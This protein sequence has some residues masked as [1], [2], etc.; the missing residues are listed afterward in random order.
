MVLLIIWFI[1]GIIGYQ[2]DFNKGNSGCFGSL[3]GFLLGPLG[4]LLIYF[5]SSNS[6]VLRQRSG[7]TK[8]CP[9]CKEYIKFNAD[10][11]KHCHNRLFEVIEPIEHYSKEQQLSEY[12]HKKSKSDLRYVDIAILTIVSVI[13]VSL[14]LNEIFDFSMYGFD[15]YRKQI[16]SSS[17]I[18]NLDNN[19]ELTT[20]EKE[21]KLIKSIR[22]E[23]TILEN[24]IDYS[25]YRGS[26]SSI[27]KEIKLFNKWSKI[28][29]D[30]QTDSSKEVKKIL[31]KFKNKVISNQVKEFP[32][33][34]KEFSKVIGSIGL[35]D[36]IEVISFGPKNTNIKF[37]GSYYALKSNISLNHSKISSV[38][39]YLRFKKAEYFWFKYDEDYVTY[40]IISSKDN[41]IDYSYS[42]ENS[43]E[44]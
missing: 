20:E 42:L 30:N 26:L 23:L 9:F 2:I 25:Q 36:D 43:N 19:N 10:Y 11:C 14:L 4:L 15:R 1:C 34:R 16:S 8:V 41:E 29:E 3:L 33:L 21:I 40:K 24:G 38:L 13:I 5:S 28:I 39:G 6:K 44:E 22:D 37:I 35:N 18:N 17:E 7:D 32:I 27:K 12:R 31:V